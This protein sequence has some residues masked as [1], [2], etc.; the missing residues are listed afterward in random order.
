MGYISTRRYG[1]SGMLTAQQLAAAKVTPE[2]VR[3]LPADVRIDI[4][5]RHMEAESAKR[6]R[7]WLTLERV[8]TTLLPLG[9]AFGFLR[10]R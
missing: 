4:A 3:Q 9:I 10:N 5:T 8:V 1:L 6:D 7:I 2:E